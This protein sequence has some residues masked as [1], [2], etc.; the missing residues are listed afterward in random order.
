LRHKDEI[1]N[2]LI[3]ELRPEVIG[4]TETHVT[5]QVEDHELYIDGYVCVR[6]DSESSRTGGVLLY[7]DN[8]INFDMRTVER[9]EGNWWSVMVNVK[10][11]DYKGVIM[12]VYHSP[13]AIVS[14]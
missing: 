11:R 14:F 10:E 6:G 2:V 3:K 4:L 9:D 1:V 12:L 7:L 8:R 13:V 5:R